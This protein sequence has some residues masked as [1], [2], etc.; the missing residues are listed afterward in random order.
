MTTW[1]L[2]TTTWE[3]E[4]SVL[5]G[6]GV[7]LWAYTGLLR[8]RLA[9]QSIWYVL[10][11][12]VLLLALLSP[13][14]MLGDIYL[15]SAHM[16]QHLLLVVP[17][18]LLSGTPEGGVRRILGRTPVRR[19]EQM[20]RRPLLAWILGIGN[21]YLWHV[22]RLYNA[23][24][25]HEGLH[26]IE[27]LCFLVTATIFWWPV[28]TPLEERRLAPLTALVYLAAAAGA[29]TFLG[30]VLTFAPSGMYPAYLN[31][32]D[33]L[34]LLPLLRQGWGLSPDI[35]QQLGGLLMWVPG[36]LVF[37]TAIL[38]TCVR[39]YRLPETDVVSSEF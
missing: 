5:L 36:G 12:M 23:A 15:F 28:L 26:I 22:P 14:D 24:L 35:D 13:L 4:P 33:R 6:C 27:H 31:P 10:G 2:L 32:T 7:L 20:L 16:L 18:L 39:W 38:G 8:G 1:Q 25:T 34:G 17:P 9:L 11:V 21:L 29:N 37:L 3:L 30:I 19:G